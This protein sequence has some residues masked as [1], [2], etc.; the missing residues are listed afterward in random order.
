M[1]QIFII[2]KSHNHSNLDLSKKKKPSHHSFKYAHIQNSLISCYP[3]LCTNFV[4][5]HKDTKVSDSYIARDV[6]NGHIQLHPLKLKTQ[7]P[8][9]K[10]ECNSSA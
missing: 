6:I 8:L 2:V 9:Y 1:R 3:I 7:S 5:L 4:T 10:T